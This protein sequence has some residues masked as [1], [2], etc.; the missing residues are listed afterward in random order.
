M[1]Q[2]GTQPILIILTTILVLIIQ[3]MEETQTKSVLAGQVQIL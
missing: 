3:E 1:Y 2:Q